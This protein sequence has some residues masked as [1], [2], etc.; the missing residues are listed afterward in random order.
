[1]DCN[2]AQDLVAQAQQHDG[3]LQV[4]PDS[5]LNHQLAP[6]SVGLNTSTGAHFWEQRQALAAAPRNSSRYELS[7]VY[8]TMMGMHVR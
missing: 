1:M 6:H 7:L 5:N 8:A 3:R 4:P 2:Y